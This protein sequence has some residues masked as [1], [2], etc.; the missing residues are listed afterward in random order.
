[1]RT[2]PG[3][4]DLP[5]QSITNAFFG[6]GVLPDAPMDEM[7][8]FVMMTV[9]SGLALREITSARMQWVNAITELS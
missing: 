3:R 5:V 4:R 1:M 9:W 8:P 6:K 2:N 7:I